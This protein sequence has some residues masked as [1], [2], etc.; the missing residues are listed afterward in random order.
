MVT[1]PCLW[2]PWGQVLSS[3]SIPI[4]EASPMHPEGPMVLALGGEA[5]LP[6]RMQQRLTGLPP[7]HR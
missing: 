2:V 7:M 4:W 5:S 6:S 3:G 1:V